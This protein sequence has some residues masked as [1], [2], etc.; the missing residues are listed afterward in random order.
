MKK[1]FLLFVIILLCYSCEDKFHNFFAGKTDDVIFTDLDPNINFPYPKMRDSIDIDNDSKYD[2]YFELVPFATQTGFIVLPAVRSTSN[3]NIL[4]DSE[5]NMP[6]ALSSGE[7]IDNSKKWSTPDTLL[8]LYY[9]K[10]QSQDYY[11]TIGHWKDQQD[12]YL[13]IKYKNKLGWL[14]ISTTPGYQIKEMGLEN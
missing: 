13:G 2:I 11:I 1:T 5:D 10:Q 4:L 12:K 14:K 9:F 3:L 7:I 6:V 8:R